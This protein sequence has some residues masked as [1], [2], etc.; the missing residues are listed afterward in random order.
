MDFACVAWR[1]AS[2]L[3][4]APLRPQLPEGRSGSGGG[5]S[6]RG[7]FV[8]D[9]ANGRCIGE[10]GGDTGVSAW[11]W[12]ATGAEAIGVK[13]ADCVMRGCVTCCAAPDTVPG[14]IV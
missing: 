8:I 5:A 11:R 3:S 12:C 1:L 9:D 14:G 7:M 2:A 6:R 4:I 13:T 10:P